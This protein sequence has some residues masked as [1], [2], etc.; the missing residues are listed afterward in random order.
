[1][2]PTMARDKKPPKDAGRDQ[3]RHG[4]HHMI[5]VPEDLYEQLREAAEFNDRPITWEARAALREHIA[6]VLKRKRA[7]EGAEDTDA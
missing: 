7:A 6:A 2:M 5:R 4:P 1:M 3:D